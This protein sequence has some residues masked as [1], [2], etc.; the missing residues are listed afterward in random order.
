MPVCQKR[1]FAVN[2][3]TH[4]HAHAHWHDRLHYKSYF[5]LKY[6]VTEI[7]KFVIIYKLTQQVWMFTDFLFIF[8]HVATTHTGGRMKLCWLPRLTKLLCCLV[9]WFPQSTILSWSQIRSVRLRPSRNF[10]GR[11][12]VIDLLFLSYHVK[13]EPAW[14][15]QVC[16]QD[17][18]MNCGLY[19]TLWLVVF[20]WCLFRNVFSIILFI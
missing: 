12:P 3:C 5:N 2:D 8:M 17:R 14:M 20:V 9:P 6:A 16:N 15:P 11:R 19:S 18:I 4:T 10:L 1:F 13:I 7:P